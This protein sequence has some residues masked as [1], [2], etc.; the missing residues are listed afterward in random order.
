MDKIL[1]KFNLKTLWMTFKS[2]TFLGWALESN[3]TDPFLFA[4]YS[5]IKPITSAA[6]LIVM[7]SIISQ[8][9][10][11]SPMFA[12][13]YLGNAFFILV[14]AVLQGVSFG[15]IDDREHYRTLKYIYIAPIHITVYLVGRSVATVLT[16]ILSVI[17][18]LLFGV[19]F[20]KLPLDFQQIDWLLFV[21]TMLIGFVMMA[22]LGFIIGGWS[23]VIKNNPW[24]LG[25]T[26]GAAMFIFSGAIFPLSVLPSFLQ[27]I[28]YV[29]PVSYWLVLIRRALMPE[30]AAAF[31]MFA[32]LSNLQLLT[33]LTIS[34]VLFSTLGLFAFYRFDHVARERGYIDMVSNY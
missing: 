17:I 27:G 19:V 12:Y 7:Y 5:V 4:V 1:H 33:I 23:L 32:S 28:G 13:I 31:P 10:F 21:I 30:V 2:A 20:F 22:G 29:I 26:V 9:D 34:A 25:E 24:T 6:I 14:G 3:W 18:T 8:E 16:R 11:S 15:I